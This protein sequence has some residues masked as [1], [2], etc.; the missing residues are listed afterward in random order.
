MKGNRH[1]D[2]KLSKAM[3]GILV[4][5]D[6]GIVIILAISAPIMGTGSS[7]SMTET[8]IVIIAFIGISLVIGLAVA[9]E[10]TRGFFSFKPR[11]VVVRSGM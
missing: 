9:A 11:Y 7:S 5:E 2:G 4:M 8:F 10:A 1:I 3:T 6:V